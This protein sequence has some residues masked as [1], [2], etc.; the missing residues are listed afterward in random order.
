MSAKS[1][2][3]MLLKSGILLEMYE[4]YDLSGNWEEDKHTFEKIYEAEESFTTNLEIEDGYE[5]F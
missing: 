1:Q 3:K 4:E 2:Y 5:E